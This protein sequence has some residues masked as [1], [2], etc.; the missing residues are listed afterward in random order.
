ML[1]DIRYFPV[2]WVDGMK[3]SSRDFIAFENAVLD[4]VRDVRSSQLNAYQYG[5][6]PTNHI[7]TDNYPK[8]VY[9][10]VNGMLVL[11]ECRAV[12]PGGQRVEITEA[13]F[14]RNRYP[15]QLPA[16]SLSTQE[17]GRFDV[18][19]RVDVSERVGA[20]EFAANNPPRYSLVSPSYQLSLRPH[21]GV[22]VEQ[23]NFLKISELEVREGRLE[24]LT[25][26]KRYIPPCVS[27]NAFMGLK[28]FHGVGEER[29]KAIVQHYLHLNRRMN[30]EIRNEIA[31]EA[32]LLSEKL[33]SAVV[34][35]LSHYRYLLPLYPPIF[36]VVYFKDYARAVQFQLER[37]FRLKFINDSKPALLEV[38]TSLEKTEPKHAAI[39]LSLDRS[40]AFLQELEKFLAELSEF[41][42]DDQSFET[43][44]HNREALASE[45]WKPAPEVLRPKPPVVP[46]PEPPKTGGR[47]F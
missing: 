2:N 13:N 29:L 19:V 26:T 21:D 18:Y 20:G 32:V 33:V 16:V 46:P 36:T 4:N 41:R 14:E 35:S 3:I 24:I 6:L 5:L 40:L 15:A 39:L 42:Y 34:A 27:M 28:R 10:Q 8:L 12:T 45:L 7:E 31:L 1:P 11:K 38:I 47:K 43:Y 9:D 30:G 22:L 37:P 25:S 23:E 17:T 44:D